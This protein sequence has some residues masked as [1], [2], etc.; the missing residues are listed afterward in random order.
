MT[1]LLHHYGLF[2]K[3][4]MTDGRKSYLSMIKMLGYEVAREEWQPE[5]P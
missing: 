1:R 3:S 2:A 5:K 4:I